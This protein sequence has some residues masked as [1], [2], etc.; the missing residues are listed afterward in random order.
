MEGVSLTENREKKMGK[1]RERLV[2]GRVGNGGGKEE[3]T[4]DGVKEEVGVMSIADADT[5]GSRLLRRHGWKRKSTVVGSRDREGAR[6][7]SAVV[8]LSK[9]TLRARGG[10]GRAREGEGKASERVGRGRETEGRNKVGWQ[11]I[12]AVTA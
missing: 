10:Q 4:Y 1:G 11:S 8:V 6:C 9:P 12:S 3:G 7:W 2:W 5:A